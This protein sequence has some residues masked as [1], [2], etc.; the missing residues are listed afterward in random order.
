LGHLI[1]GLR[2]TTVHKEE[3]NDGKSGNLNGALITLREPPSHPD[4]R[5]QTP[6]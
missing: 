2:N 1:I 4:G 3:N 6:A 5:R